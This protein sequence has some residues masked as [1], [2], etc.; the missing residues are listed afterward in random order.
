MTD[1]EVDETG[2]DDPVSSRILAALAEDPEQLL[3]P[4]L[5]AGFLAYQVN[6]RPR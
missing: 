1:W 6:Y 3:L 4:G 5:P 2:A